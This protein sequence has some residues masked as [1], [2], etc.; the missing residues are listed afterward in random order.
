MR[1]TTG[2]PTV[3]RSLGVPVNRVYRF[4]WVAAGALAGLAAALLG[5][6]FGGIAPFDMTRLGLRA[7]AGA[8]IGGLDSVWGA[9][10]GSLAIG[11]L[12]A[13]VGGSFD[14]AGRG[15]ARGAGPRPGDAPAPAA[16]RVRDRRCA[17]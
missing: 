14:T 5:S 4:A 15:R 12:E 11:V 8:V 3:A 13:V 10:V 16:R 7:L 1:A 9:I 2:D 6:A 17:A